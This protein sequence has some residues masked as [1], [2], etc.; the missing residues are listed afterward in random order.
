LIHPAVWQQYTGQKLGGTVPL[1]GELRPHLT[2]C[3]LGRGLPP[4][5]WHLDPSSHLAT[6]DMGGKLGGY[7][8]LSWGGAGSHQTQCG[9]GRGLP[10]YQ[11]ASWSIQPFGHNGYG[12]KTEG[13]APF[14]GIWVP[15]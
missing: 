4:T 10:P 14:G 9:L 15:I 6:T 11:M 13:C 2:Q 7:C 3:R 8:G 5:T 12:T 1:R